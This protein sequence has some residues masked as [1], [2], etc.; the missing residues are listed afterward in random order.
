ML[1]T[2]LHNLPEITQI[3]LWDAEDPAKSQANLPVS[4]KVGLVTSDLAAVLAQPDLVFA[5]VCVRTDLNAA[6]CHQVIAAGKHL[7]S[8]KPVGLTA[9]EV[10]GLERAAKQAHVAASVLYVRRLHPC[11]VA[12]RPIVQ[13]GELGRLLSFEAR[14]LTTQVRFRHPESWLFRKE[15]AGGGIL[16]WLGCHCL[17]LIRNISGEEITDVSALLPIRSGEKIEV[18]DTAALTLRLSSGAVGTFHA[19]YTLAYSGGGYVNASG[20]DSYLGFNFER[21]RIVW[22][23]L[24]PHLQI[25]RPPAAG[26]PPKQTVSFELPSSSSYGGSGGE[27]FFRQFIAATQGEGQP[28]TTLSDALAVAHVVESAQRSNGSGRLESIPPLA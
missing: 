16:L 14:F 2:T 26:Q 9:T 7:L 10:E 19:G 21:G 1:L 28:P 3:S 12:A 25:E 6:V 17:D 5:I 15:N 22:P 20:Y 4:K 24:D 27:V 11:M 23:D 13:S 18:E 8:E